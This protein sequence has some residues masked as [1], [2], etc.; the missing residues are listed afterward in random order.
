VS[1]VNRQED[2]LIGSTLAGGADPGFADS[3]EIGG[4]LSYESL[5]TLKAVGCLFGLLGCVCDSLRVVVRVV[6]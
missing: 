5:E 6:V 3:V 1:Y 4:A 2:R